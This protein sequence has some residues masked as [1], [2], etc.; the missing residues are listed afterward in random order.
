MRRIA[1]ITMICAVTVIMT[2][3]NASAQPTI[4]G[5]F[6]PGEW[7]G[8][9]ITT[10]TSNVIPGEYELPN[11]YGYA[12]EDYLY[13]GFETLGAQSSFNVDTGYT[14]VMAANIGAARALTSSSTATL[15]ENGAWSF[16]MENYSDGG[17]GVFGTGHSQYKY[18]DAGVDGPGSP[19]TFGVD[20]SGLGVDFSIAHSMSGSTQI[21]EYALAIDALEAAFGRTYQDGTISAGDELKIVGFFNRDSQAWAPISYPDGGPGSPSFGDQNGYATITVAEPVPVPSAVLL[22]MLGLSVAGVKLRKRA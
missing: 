2:A 11:V 8:L 9:S 12:D 15:G 17:S 3:G 1:L 22:G 4:D 13:M 14:P 16:A 10:G 18:N 19:Q 6:S 21:I 20:A 7:D 5:V